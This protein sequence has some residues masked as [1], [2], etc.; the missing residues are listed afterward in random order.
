MCEYK[1]EYGIAAYKSEEYN[2]ILKIREDVLRKP[3][4]LLLTEKDQEDDEK[5]IHIWL[6]VNKRI[7][8]TAMLTEHSKQELR[9]RMVGVRPQVRKAG[10]GS[11]LIKYAEGLAAGKG[12]EKIIMDARITAKNFYDKLGYSSSGEQYERVGIPH[13][14]MSKKV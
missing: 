5:A 3:I 4:G 10:L 9:L 14:F 12:Y 6:S 2:K 7:V 8:A 13:I 11:R 1:I